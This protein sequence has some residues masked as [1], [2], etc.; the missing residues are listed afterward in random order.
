MGFIFLE[1]HFNFQNIL[2]TSK[3]EIYIKSF[4]AILILKFAMRWT[5]Y[6]LLG[7][8]VFQIHKI[9]IEILVFCCILVC[10]SSI[11]AI[12]S[13]RIGCT[14]GSVQLIRILNTIS[15]FG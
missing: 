13:S 14:F 11:R 2:F 7:I 6:Y 15:S 10:V 1:S 12:A 4:H 5:R 9:Y 8:A 3:F